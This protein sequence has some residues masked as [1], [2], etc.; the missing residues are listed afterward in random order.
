MVI[1]YIYLFEDIGKWHSIHEV[2][3]QLSGV[4][5]LSFHHVNP[6]EGTRSSGLE[7]VSLLSH[8]MGPRM[9]LDK[10]WSKLCKWT[11]TSQA[12]WHTRVSPALEG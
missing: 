4:R 12:W 7:Q 1:N 5:S 10:P 8:L 3:G 11:S 9:F 6:K 2:R